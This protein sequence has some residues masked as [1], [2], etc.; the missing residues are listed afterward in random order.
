MKDDKSY[1]IS[2][3][4]FYIN[5]IFLKMY[6]LYTINGKHLNFIF[7]ITLLILIKLTQLL[8]L[9]SYLRDT[10]WNVYTGNL[11]FQVISSYIRLANNLRTLLQEFRNLWIDIRYIEKSIL[12]YNKIIH[13]YSIMMK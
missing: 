7:T 12:R 1:F 2:H 11:D 13:Q 3:E 9:I 10:I 6:S 4:E 5:M 8:L